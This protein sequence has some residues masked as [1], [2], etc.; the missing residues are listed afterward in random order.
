MSTLAACCAPA[1]RARSLT[2]RE[3]GLRRRALGVIGMILLL[4]W[5][6]AAACHAVHLKSRQDA[7]ISALIAAS[8]C[9]TAASPATALPRVPDPTDA[10]VAGDPPS[11]SLGSAGVGCLHC[12]SGGCRA[13]AGRPDGGWIIAVL[14]AAAAAG[15]TASRVAPSA[16]AR[17][18]GH[19]VRGPPPSGV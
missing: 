13:A 19:P 4:A 14:L 18:N 9:S 5:Q 17:R 12:A 7:T 10:P 15:P 16:S 8:L 6:S 3:R 2:A 1:C 11:G